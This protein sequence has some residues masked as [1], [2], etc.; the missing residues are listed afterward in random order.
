MEYVALFLWF[1]LCLL[2]GSVMHTVLRGPISYRVIALATTPGVVVRKFSQTVAALVCG[3]TVTG[4]KIYE[5]SPRDISFKAEGIPSVAKVLVPVAPLFG[6]VLV[7]GG[8]NALLG[9][10]LQL[11]YAPP[12]LASLDAGGMSGFFKGIWLLLS[13]L[14]G[15]ALRADWRSPEFYVM[16]VLIFSLALGAC[17]PVGKLREA[18]AGVG[19][20]VV[21]LA[22][23][24]GL[25]ARPAGVGAVAASASPPGRAEL[26]VSAARGFMVDCA[27]VAFALMLFGMLEA[28]AVGVVTRVYEM[29]SGKPARSVASKR[30]AMYLR[31]EDRSEAA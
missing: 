11:D 18:L 4:V 12:P 10:P 5:T 13:G 29:F 20:L 23:V 28:L 9:Y 30:S 3:G 27:G 15:Q 25:V 14:V 19:L 1:S 31:R 17:E 2:L 21:G 16:L 8:L 26:W 22:L 6:C 7:L 24:C